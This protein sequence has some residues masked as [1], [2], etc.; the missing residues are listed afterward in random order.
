M[1]TAQ[2][3]PDEQP[4]FKGRLADVAEALKLIDHWLKTDDRSDD[5]G[6]WDNLKALLD[7]D[8]LSGRKLFCNE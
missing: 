2:K 4:P 3:F 6:D 5:T 7:Q 1:T 8:R